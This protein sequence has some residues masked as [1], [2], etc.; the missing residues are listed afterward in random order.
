M[1]DLYSGED[2]WLEAMTHLGFIS[3][4]SFWTP[5][6]SREEEK[7]PPAIRKDSTI[8]QNNF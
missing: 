2:G 3:S 6:D 5:H 7:T 1:P 8:L 4:H